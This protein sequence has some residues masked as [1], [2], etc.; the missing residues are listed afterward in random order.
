[1]VPAC[2]DFAANAGESARGWTI[3]GTLSVEPPPVRG[4]RCALGH[5]RHRS[6]PPT[7][8]CRLAGADRPDARRARGRRRA[9]HRSRRHR[10]AAGAARQCGAGR[11]SRAALR[12]LPCLR[13]PVPGALRVD[14]H[15][16]LPALRARTV[17]I[18]TLPGRRPCR[19]TR[20]ARM[21]IAGTVIGRVARAS[22]WSASAT[23]RATRRGLRGGARYVGGR[24]SSRGGGAA[25]NVQ[26][27]RA[28]RGHA[29]GE[30][31]CSAT[32][33]LTRI[34]IGS[35]AKTARACD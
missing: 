9:R 30:R 27:N 35:V 2:T 23:A 3:F 17:A 20:L 32:Q 24:A 4:R 13:C 10:D 34:H 25:R 19:R 31:V 22:L 28:A 21:G 15:V 11:G 14:D 8:D 5:R 29:S 1:M 18:A 16:G 6:L 7:L 26:V 33:A 12:A